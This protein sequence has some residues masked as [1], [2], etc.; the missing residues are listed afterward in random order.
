MKTE[1]S[2]I[3]K[4]FD[5]LAT[6]SLRKQA[7]E[8][9]EAG[10]FAIDTKA[11]VQKVVRYNQSKQIL[12]AA[13][14]KYFLSDY[15]RVMCVGFGKAAFNAV[16]ELQLILSDRITCGYVIDL[17]EGSLGNI[18]CKIGTHPYP[19]KINID[20]TKEL[21]A[22]LSSCT[23]K[24][25]V[26]CVV[27][28]GGSA[29]LCSPHDMSCEQEVS[30]IAALT[31]KGATIAEL[32]TVRKHISTVK[33]G[34]LAKTMYP[35]TVISLIFSDVPGDDLSL[36][37]S[38]PTVMD[39]SLSKDAAAVLKKYD[40]L[41]ACQLP[42]CKLI[43]TPKDLKYFAKV[44]NV[45]AVSPKQALAAMAERAEE[46]GFDVTIF[47]EQFQ[48]EARLLGPKIIAASQ[49]RQ[50]L[51]G[52]GES[53]VKI[54]GNGTGGRNQEMAL[55]ALSLIAENQVLVCAASDG[56]DNTDA[57]GAVVD[58]NSKSRAGALALD[59]KK[60]LDNNDSY[61]F[62]EKLGDRL[63]TGETETNVSDFFVCLK[64]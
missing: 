63:L 39:K 1:K 2:H 57:A 17:K 42:S 6:S 33:G 29:L 16:S 10:F 18:T 61:N 12:W 37:A 21:L 31:V 3:I 27:S 52:A 13:S 51:L 34:Q 35:A 45:L 24:D 30:I 25:L 36:V 62:F 20:A 64:Q 14:K 50:A 4:N 8:I 28:G 60:Y 44:Q 41:E 9:V 58:F 11:A 56:H 15:E 23:E 5:R 43:E 22:M 7:L 40:V 19:T 54:V 47:S 53:T 55:S 59:P 38:G 46:L 49:R 48:G 32:N 26:I